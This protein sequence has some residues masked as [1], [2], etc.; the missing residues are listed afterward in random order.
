M[1]DSMYIHISRI[2]IVPIDYL[3]S[4]HKHIRKNVLNMYT[5]ICLLSL[6]CFIGISPSYAQQQQQQYSLI[7]QWGSHG[8]GD[9]EFISP[10]SIAID[11]QGNVFVV[12]VLNSRIQKFNNNGTF[13]TKWGSRGTGD[14]EF[15]SPNGIAIDSVDNMY[16]VDS[17]KMEIQKFNNNGTFLTKWGSEGTGDGQFS[18]PYGITIDSVGNVF[19]VD[20]DSARIQ[21]F[22]NNGTFLTKWGSYCDIRTGYQCDNRNNNSMGDGE[23]NSPTWAA[24]DLEDRIYIADTKNSRI[25]KFNNNGTFLTKWGSYNSD[26]DGESSNPEGIDVDSSNTVFVSDI[27]NQK[28]LA[29]T[30]VSNTSK[31][32]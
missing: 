10:R 25:Q 11:S 15:I 20:I 5:L 23:F 22:N 29:F 6:G 13:L 21:K 3:K 17:Q 28:I 32:N 19:V 16:I 24:S 7:D 2:C 8:T 14:G 26:D 18:E 1:V 9:G 30:P 27:V 12:D 31:I 4:S